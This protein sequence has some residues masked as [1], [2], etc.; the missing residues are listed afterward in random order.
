MNYDKYL[1]PE[2]MRYHS[3]GT[4]R[5]LANAASDKTEKWMQE[6]VLKQLSETGHREAASMLSDWFEGAT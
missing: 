1:T 4:Q 6:I 3:A 5:A 2:E